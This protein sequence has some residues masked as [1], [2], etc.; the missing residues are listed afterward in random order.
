MQWNLNNFFEKITPRLC[1]AR[2]IPFTESVCDYD[3]IKGQ[4]I[5]NV[6]E[7]SREFDQLENRLD[8]LTV[9]TVEPVRVNKNETRGVKV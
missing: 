7:A 6:F 1:P 8:F 5:R 2:A 4:H 3:I 9:E